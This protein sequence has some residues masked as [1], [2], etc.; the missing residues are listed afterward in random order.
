[1]MILEL[2][3][4]KSRS[5]SV[6]EGGR[7]FQKNS[8]TFC[9]AGARLHGEAVSSIVEKSDPGG[10]GKHTMSLKLCPVGGARPEASAQM[11]TTLCRA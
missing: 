7:V 11:F 4:E 8:K 1:M 9:T 10:S 3:L 5:L 6:K 2:G